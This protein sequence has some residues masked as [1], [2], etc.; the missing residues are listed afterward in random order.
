MKKVLLLSGILGALYYYREQVSEAIYSWMESKVNFKVLTPTNI[1]F[2]MDGTINFD[3]NFSLNNFLPTPLSIDT[4]ILT[5]YRATGTDDNGVIQW[6]KIA[7]RNSEDTTKTIII[8]PGENTS[9][10]Q[11]SMPVKSSA[12]NLVSAV[13]SR[14]TGTKDL[15]KLEATG[16]IEGETNT[17]THETTFEL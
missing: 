15:Y 17:F 5:V 6:E 2:N 3:F 4:L 12:I 7:E 11:V 9:K 10:I 14:I 1:K 16:T 13:T 8:E